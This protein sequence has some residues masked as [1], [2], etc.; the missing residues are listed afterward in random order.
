MCR[1]PCLYGECACLRGCM[2]VCECVCLYGGC[3]ACVCVSDHVCIVIVCV[4]VGVCMFVNVRACMVGVL[5]LYV[6]PVVFVL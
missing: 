3:V 2:L 1:W 5:C 4:C 6:S